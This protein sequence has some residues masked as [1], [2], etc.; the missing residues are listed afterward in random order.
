MNNKHE[1][2][3]VEVIVL[4]GDSGESGGDSGESGGD[5]GDKWM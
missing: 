1:E 2:Y 4:I 3:L 5:S